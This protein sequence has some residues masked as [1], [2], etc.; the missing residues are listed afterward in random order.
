M[1]TTACQFHNL[2]FKLGYTLK[3]GLQDNSL[4]SILFFE[5]SSQVVLFTDRTDKC[6]FSLVL[7]WSSGSVML[8]FFGKVEFPLISRCRFNDLIDKQFLALS[9]TLQAL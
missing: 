4:C 5:Q 7:F 1:H 2:V 8:K 3:C 9:R 6:Q